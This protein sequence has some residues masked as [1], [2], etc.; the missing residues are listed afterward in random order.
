MAA[1]A[2]ILREYVKREH[3]TDK[4]AQKAFYKD[5]FRRHAIGGLQ[6]TC[7]DHITLPSTTLPQEPLDSY[8][9]FLGMNC[10]TSDEEKKAEQE[11]LAQTFLPFFRTTYAKD[12][13]KELKAVTLNAYYGDVPLN[14]YV[15]FAQEKGLGRDVLFVKDTYQT[16]APDPF[17]RILVNI[18][19]L[20]PKSSQA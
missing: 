5:T 3:C 9:S 16:L 7:K 4:E 2:F 17:L 11:A 20:T 19:L 12:V 13:F 6:Y 8:K 10:D 14:S 18:K 1:S 15:E